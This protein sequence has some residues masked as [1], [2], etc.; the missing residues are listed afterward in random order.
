MDRENIWQNFGDEG[1]GLDLKKSPI[2][3]DESSDL[4]SIARKECLSIV[5]SGLGYLRNWVSCGGCGVVFNL[6]RGK[7]G[8][9][10]CC[11]WK[12]KFDRGGGLVLVEMVDKKQRDE[13][14]FK[15]LA[16]SL[17]KRVLAENLGEGVEID[18]FEEYK[19]DG[20][21]FAEDVI[22]KVKKI[23]KADCPCCKKSVDWDKV[24]PYSGLFAV[25]KRCPKC[26]ENAFALDRD[27]SVWL[28]RNLEAEEEPF[29][30]GEAYGFDE[31]ETEE[32]G[33]I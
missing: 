31:E 28:R 1:E 24:E 6:D 18:D 32:E 2:E 22:L 11:G 17:G 27:K 4:K 23:G 10:P 14:T 20:G 19:I 21:F 25:V 13:R 30:L 7:V 8:E 3:V 16:D 15:E 29:N 33:L 9:C 5:R 12:F 26:E